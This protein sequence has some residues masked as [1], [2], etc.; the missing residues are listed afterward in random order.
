MVLLACISLATTVLLI[1]LVSTRGRAA[2]DGDPGRRT[3]S[4]ERGVL[5]ILGELAAFELETTEGRAFG[6]EGLAGKVWVVGFVFT[7]CTGPCPAIVSRMAALQADITRAG[8]SGDVGLLSLSVDPAY[9]TPAVLGEYARLAKADHGIWTWVTGERRVVSSLVRDG[10]RL[11][12]SSAEGP[13]VHSQRLVLVDGSGRVRGY[14]EALS[15]EGYEALW[16]DVTRLL[17]DGG[18]GLVPGHTAAVKQAR[19]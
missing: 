13:I 10:F 8:L 3:G 9:D 17:V 6:R 15:E 16:G 5:P 1:A 7:R 18:E 4:T 2:G 14:Y 19:R 12:L 11:P